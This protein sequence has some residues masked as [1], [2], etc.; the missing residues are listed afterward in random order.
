MAVCDKV[1]ELKDEVEDVG[2]RT[3]S[4]KSVCEKN[5]DKPLAGSLVGFVAGL[6]V[7]APVE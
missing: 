2:Q 7:R 6:L 4:S 1:V 5:C 3:A